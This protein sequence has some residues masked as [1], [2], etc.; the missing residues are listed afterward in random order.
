MD[1]SA[2]EIVFDETGCNF[3]HQADKS[4]KEIEYERGNLQRVVERIKKDGL[5]K[6]YDVLLGI[7]GGV[8]SSLCLHH[9]ISLGLRPLTFSIDNSWNDPRADENIMRLVEGLKV[10][11]YRYTIDTYKFKELQGAFLKAGQINVEIAT[12]HILLASSYE[13]ATKYGIKYIISG[14]NVATESI[15]PESWGYQPRDLVH[16]KDVYKWAI[17]KELKGLPMCSLW[18][19]NV[20]K[21]WH[22]IETMYLLDYLDY[23]RTEA[24]KL[25]EEKYGYK[26]Y[27]DKHC[28]NVFTTWFQNFYLYQKFGIDKR[29][30]HFSSLICS[31]QMTRKEA[32]FQ[33]Q[34]CP[35]YPKLGIEQRVMSYSKR[36]YTDFETDEKTWNLLCKIVKILRKLNLRKKK[37]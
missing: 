18:Q 16:I 25:L 17:G 6:S 1:R 5:G 19:Y 27:G 12:D 36:P 3:C 22:G 37:T 33:L 13:M 29:K 7:S 28:E 24:I 21:W 11:F 10:P 26:S 30:A 4:L 35:V 34:A 32:M 31:G 14:G 15:M 20:Y 8:D 23:N 9:L 2:N